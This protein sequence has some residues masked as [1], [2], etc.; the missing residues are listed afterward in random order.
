MKSGPTRRSRLVHRKRPLQGTQRK[1]A[2]VE[3]GLG[4]ACPMAGF[5]M[6]CHDLGIR[7]SAPSSTGSATN[8]TLRPSQQSSRSSIP[9]RTARC[10]STSPRR[11]SSRTP[12]TRKTSRST[13]GCAIRQFRSATTCPAT[14]SPR[15]STARP[16]ST[17]WLRHEAS[18]RAAFPHQR[19]EL[20]ALQ[21]LRHQGPGAEHRLDHA[22]R[23]RRAKLPGHV[24]GGGAATCGASR[25]C[26]RTS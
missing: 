10:R 16:A 3:V 5:D 25:G 18:G 20:R 15:G 4:W 23:R 8:E 19:P 6:W 22:R 26:P 9:S 2:L 21:N 14:A 24:N 1:P 13:C 7:C 17:K 12:I 11:Y